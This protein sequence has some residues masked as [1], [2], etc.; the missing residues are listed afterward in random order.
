MM[1]WSKDAREVRTLLDALSI[2]E[3]VRAYLPRATSPIASALLLSRLAT[4]QWR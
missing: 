2:A 3:A 1:R 4:H